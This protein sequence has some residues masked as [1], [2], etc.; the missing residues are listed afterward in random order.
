MAKE[1]STTEK[2][3]LGLGAVVV[4]LGVA[5]A[6]RHYQRRPRKSA[7][8]DNLIILGGP[9]AGKS[10]QC[11]KLIEAYGG[12]G[13]HI[14]A[15]DLL[16]DQVLQGT[17]LGKEAKPYMDKGNLV[18]DRLVIEIVVDDLQKLDR[19]G[20]RW[21][22]D[23]F[24]RTPQQAEK[25]KQENLL[26]KAVLL[27]QVPDEEAFR[28]SAGRLEDPVT[29]AI[30]HTTFDPPPESVKGRLRKRNDDEE[31]VVRNRIANFK[32]LYPMIDQ[33]FADVSK[34]QIDGNHPKEAVW[35]L[36]KKSLD[37]VGFQ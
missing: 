8:P 23:G 25:L 10:T 32:K 33:E 35:Q 16:R 18:P 5:A 6:V 17:D 2:I 37:S 29:K 21:F 9:S 13:R 30:Y 11:K 34:F 26:P 36:I 22:L 28:R 24:P 19:K 15:G 27:L 12:R 1:R 31:V 14:S 7:R 4:G 3:L 20:V